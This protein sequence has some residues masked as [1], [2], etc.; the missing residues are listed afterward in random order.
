[1]RLLLRD[2]PHVNVVKGLDRLTHAMFGYLLN[3]ICVLSSDLH[4]L[5]PVVSHLA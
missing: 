5:F 2:E 1:M 4:G 3:I